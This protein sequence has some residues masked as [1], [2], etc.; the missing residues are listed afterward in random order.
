[1]STTKNP[2]LDEMQVLVAGSQT[3]LTCDAKACGTSDNPCFEFTPEG[4]VACAQLPWWNGH[5][6]PRDTLLEWND[7]LQRFAFANKAD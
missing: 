6:V 5:P 1:M 2:T 3:C 4:A 7:M